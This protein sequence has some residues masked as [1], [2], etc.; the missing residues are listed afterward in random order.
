MIRLVA[1]NRSL[2]VCHTC[3]YGSIH[4]IS[5]GQVRRRHLAAIVVEM[6]V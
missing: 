4:R 6:A 2:V 1:L 5:V 3:M